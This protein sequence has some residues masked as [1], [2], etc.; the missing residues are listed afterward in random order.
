MSISFY[1]LYLTRIS[2]EESGI[3]VIW[4]FVSLQ[5]ILTSFRFFFHSL[6]LPKEDFAF[7]LSES[8]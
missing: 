5:W 2:N 4:G 7:L 3:G 6:D 8:C 1:S